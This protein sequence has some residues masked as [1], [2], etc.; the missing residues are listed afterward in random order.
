MVFKNCA[1]DVMVLRFFLCIVED[2]TFDIAVKCWKCA[3][4]PI[5]LTAFDSSSN[6]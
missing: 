1:V 3:I 6:Y 4:K 5:E 2:L